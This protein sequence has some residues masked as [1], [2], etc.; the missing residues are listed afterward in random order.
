MIK[1]F[2]DASVLFSAA[3]RGSLM[4]RFIARL[5]RVSN[6]VTN[7]YAA[8]EARRNLTLKFPEAVDNLV[9]LLREMVFVL[10]EASVSGPELP[11]KD[12][13]ILAGA[14]ASRC[15]HLLTSDRRDFGGFFGKT[16][17]GVK[18]VSPQMFADEL[19]SLGLLE[20]N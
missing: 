4:E 14:V 13:P 5:L 19:A 9:R 8:E 1:V 15:T 17:A 10:E 3:R 20:K 6:C 16:I 7:A 12:Q 2:L 18:V 11:E